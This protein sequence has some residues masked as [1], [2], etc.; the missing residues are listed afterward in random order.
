MT[1]LSR[2]EGGVGTTHQM[3][4]DVQQDSWPVALQVSQAQEPEQG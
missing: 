4:T 3:D 2:A 1:F